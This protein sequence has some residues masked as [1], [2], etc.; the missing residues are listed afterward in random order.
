M[1]IKITRKSIHSGFVG[2]HIK[3]KTNE[4]MLQLILIRI[5]LHLNIDYI[6]L[7]HKLGI[8]QVS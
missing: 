8:L 6:S 1:L 4:K 3:S 2:G 5:Q 7:K